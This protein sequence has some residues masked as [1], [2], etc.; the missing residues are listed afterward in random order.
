L[1]EH[2]QSFIIT[3]CVP[4]VTWSHKLLVQDSWN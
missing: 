3:A 1:K 4:I 2:W